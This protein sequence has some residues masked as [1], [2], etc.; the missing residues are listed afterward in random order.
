MIH[1]NER[2]CCACTACVNIC[3][4]NIIR[5]VENEKG[6]LVPKVDDE[7]CIKCG[8][9]VKVCPYNKKR[10]I[11]RDTSIDEVLEVKI[12][13]GRMKSQSGGAFYAFAKH[14]I[15]QKGIVYGVELKNDIAIYARKDTIEGIKQLRGSKYVQAVM[16]NAISQVRDDL[17]N[18]KKV[19]FSGTSCQIHGMLIYLRECGVDCTNLY[20]CDLIC[21][22]VCSPRVFDD[23]LEYLRK[24]FPN[25]TDFIF[26]DKRIAG[27]SGHVE[28][29]VT[30]QG[31]IIYSENY[32]K[33]FYENIVLRDNCYL[34][35]YAN[36]DRISDI[37]ISDFWGLQNLDIK[38]S[39][40]FGVSMV[41][42][43]TQKGLELIS[44]IKHKSLI[45]KYCYKDKQINLR[46]PT[47]RND[48]YDVFWEEYFKVG[49]LETVMKYCGFDTNDFVKISR[50]KLYQ[51]F[52]K[53]KLKDKL[54][55]F[56]YLILKR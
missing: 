17:L 23:Y 26:R 45:Q 55:I 50:I 49:F 35:Q 15:K 18:N 29:F 2:N 51:M 9:C 6:F 42:P 25:S 27:W 7:K 20:T 11:N 30:S 40:S 12:K 56:V 5:L 47:E 24:V 10:C 33:I 13:K 21:H 38:F 14:F 43:N 37:T 32:C 4:Q 44:A 22:G 46:K 19:L 48:K 39:D 41:I 31:S 53:R 54:R 34:C 3:P 1:N 36:E 16:R 52:L 8:K 28:S